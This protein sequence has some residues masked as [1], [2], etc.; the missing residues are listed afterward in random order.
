MWTMSSAG[1]CTLS[2]HSIYQ[3]HACLS[4][5]WPI[6]RSYREEEERSAPTTS[7]PFVESMYQHK[8][9][10]KLK[11]LTGTGRVVQVDRELQRSLSRNKSS[12][13]SGE[14]LTVDKTIRLK[15]ET[16]STVLAVS[17]LTLRSGAINYVHYQLPQRSPIIGLVIGN[18]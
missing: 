11:N 18:S 14:D 17:Q 5:L 13:L 10:R 15:A 6:V 1:L 16:T 4:N 12:I 7:M 8:R 2:C 3:N 9:K